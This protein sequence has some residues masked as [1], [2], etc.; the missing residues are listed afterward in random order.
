MPWAHF[1]EVHS[2]H[3]LYY[4]VKNNFI[5]LVHVC[6]TWWAHGFDF[7]TQISSILLWSMTLCHGL[8]NGYHGYP[9]S[10]NHHTATAWGTLETSWRAW[11][12]WVIKLGRRPK[13]SGSFHPTS[14]VKIHFSLISFAMANTLFLLGNIH[15]GHVAW[16]QIN[17]ICDTL[18]YDFVPEQATCWSDLIENVWIWWLRTSKLDSFLTSSPPKEIK[19]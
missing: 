7:V 12:Q 14:K 16:L 2:H 10:P 5:F 4:L 6:I 13:S 15:A 8:D 3:W 19:V 9:Y 11:K 1:K 17:F 18:F